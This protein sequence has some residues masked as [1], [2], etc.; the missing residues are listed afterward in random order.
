MTTRETD[1]VSRGEFR[2][3]DHVKISP[4]LL[5]SVQKL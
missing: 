1:L 5:L 4:I 2:D 3:P